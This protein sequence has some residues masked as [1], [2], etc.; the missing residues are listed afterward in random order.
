MS[1]LPSSRSF[2]VVL[3]A[4]VCTLAACGESVTEVAPP[5]GS[6]LYSATPST[7]SFFVQAHQDDWELFMGDHAYHSVNDGG[8]TVFVYTT[9]GDAGRETG[10]WK[11]REEGAMEATRAIAAAGTWAC[12]N[13]QVGAHSI[14]RCTYAN[15]VS[16][17]L[18]LPDGSLN[19]GL[20]F[21]STGYQSMTKLRAEGKPLVAV[22]GSTTFA[23]WADFRATI[24]RILDTE[25]KG[26]RSVVVNAPDANPVENPKD[27][28]DHWETGQ[29]VLE[30]V[31]SHRGWRKNWFMDYATQ[32]RPRNLSAAEYDHKRTAFLGYDDTVYRLVNASNYRT[33][34]PNGNLYDEWLWRSYLR[35]K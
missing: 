33:P 32:Y 13:A 5:D 22:D 2:T 11:A 12:A 35:T 15:T 27:N 34:G 20:G 18:R 1:R 7:V 9:A 23:T 31:R 29:V 30:A 14:L 21:P 24:A 6:P 25:S 26:A 17:F 16:Y 10:Y 28:P 3:A 8:K 19:M 4:S